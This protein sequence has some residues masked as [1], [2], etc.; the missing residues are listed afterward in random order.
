MNVLIV[1]SSAQGSASVSRRLAAHYAARVRQSR[2]DATIVQRD[3]GRDPLPHLHEDTVSGIRAEATT[4]AER[5]T[6]AISDTLLDEVRAADVVVIAAPMYNFGIPSTLKTWFDYILRP[7]V[8]FRYSEAGPEGLLGTRKVIVIESRA[9][10]YPPESDLQTQ[11]LRAML[12]F[13]GLGDISFVVA[14]GLAFGQDAAETAIAGAEAELDALARAP[15]SI[16][17]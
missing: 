1:D 10:Q 2:P 14:E 13:A 9:G 17:A 3:V 6:L 11:H 5:A 4:D 8:A 15:L 12:T 7:R 16:A